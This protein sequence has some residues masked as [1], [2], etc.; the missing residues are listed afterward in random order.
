MSVARLRMDDPTLANRYLAGQ[1]AGAE[2]AAFEA[3]LIEDPAV[4]RELEATA[5]LKA[6]L[7]QLRRRGDLE[8]AMP[9]Q[10]RSA[11][12]AFGLAAA[13]ALLAIGLGLNFPVGDRPPSIAADVA[14]LT[15]GHGKTLPIASSH[16][17]LRMR[18]ARADAVIALPATP[19]AI[20]L[21]VLSAEAQPQAPYR[22]R[23][24]RPA[25][26]TSRAGSVAESLI[27]AAPD[28]WVTLYLDSRTLSPG[29]YELD[30][31]PMASPEGQPEI[32]VIDIRA[33]ARAEADASA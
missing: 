19:G 18:S 12:T 9:G 26:A 6:G 25:D 14:A 24:R 29:R 27:E 3:R 30:I 8:H 21:R 5:R 1:L 15:A 10:R 4:L 23:L 22:L 32:F 7:R 2:Q 28:G 20:E 17:L 16:S 11:V 13:M 31:V 33:A